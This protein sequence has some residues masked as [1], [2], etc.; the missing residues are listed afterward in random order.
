M[1]GR[2]SD[3]ARVLPA[4]VLA[5]PPYVARTTRVHAGFDLALERIAGIVVG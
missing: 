2:C 5:E 1:L 4:F 3:G